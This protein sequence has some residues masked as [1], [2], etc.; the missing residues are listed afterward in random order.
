MRASALSSAASAS[1]CGLR[2]IGVI[3]ALESAGFKTG[4]DV[5]LAGVEFELDPG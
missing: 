3:K 4:D 1:V 2:G 5:E